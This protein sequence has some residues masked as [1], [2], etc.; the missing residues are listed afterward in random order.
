MII[1]Q[2]L[3]QTITQKLKKNKCNDNKEMGINTFKAKIRR[4]NGSLGMT[5]PAM[6]RRI[7]GIRETDFLGVKLEI[8]EKM[9]H[10]YSRAIRTG[11]S[12]SIKIPHIIR[13]NLSLDKGMECIVQVENF[14]LNWQETYDE[15]T[16]KYPELRKEKIEDIIDFI[17]FLDLYTEKKPNITFK[18]FLKKRLAHRPPLLK[19]LTAIN[20]IIEQQNHKNIKEV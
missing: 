10:F 12:L 9:I 6:N 8:R 16:S 13:V 1:I 4:L 18:E 20:D 14:G 17:D 15:L 3:L 5:I 7:L 19:R 2:D 11:N